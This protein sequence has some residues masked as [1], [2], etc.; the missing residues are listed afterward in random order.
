MSNLS[1]KRQIGSETG[2]E[3]EREHEIVVVGKRDSDVEDE[4]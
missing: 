4:G 3:I 2:R 1:G